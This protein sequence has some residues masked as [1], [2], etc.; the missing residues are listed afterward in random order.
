MMHWFY[1][2]MNG[3]ILAAADK[4]KPDIGFRLLEGTKHMKGVVLSDSANPF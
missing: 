3:C 4:G 1:C 2:W